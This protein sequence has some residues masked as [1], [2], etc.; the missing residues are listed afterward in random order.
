MEP[1]YAFKSKEAVIADITI[2]L[3]ALLGKDT[4]RE[5]CPKNCREHISK[6]AVP[7]KIALGHGFID[8]NETREDI[9]HLLCELEELL[10]IEREHII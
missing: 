8:F 1:H 10:R 4:G 9:E 2:A 5:D 6:L 7:D 3:K